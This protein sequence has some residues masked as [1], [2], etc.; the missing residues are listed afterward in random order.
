MNLFSFVDPVQRYVEAL[1]AG[2][3]PPRVRIRSAE[4]ADALKMAARLWGESNPA[5]SDPDPAFV[6]D[7]RYSMLQDNAPETAPATD[8]RGF[9][10]AGLSAT[11]CLAAGLLAGIG[12]ERFTS[13]SNLVAP[14]VVTQPR[15]RIRNRGRWFPIAR[16]SELGDNAVVRFSAGALE[17]NLVRR[18][19]E[20]FAI[21]AICSHLPCTLI[22]QQQEDNFL[23]PC[24]STPFSVYGKK[25]VERSYN[26]LTSIEVSVEEGVVRV[27]SV[28][29]PAGPPEGSAQF[30]D[31]S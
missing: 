27:W 5:A 25:L 31:Y 22:Y 6:A 26:D 12:L 19:G 10:A 30:T 3:R 4:D 13:A 28:D 2:K 24:H 29:P 8:R 18:D 20:V 21:S 14:P 15:L 7:L 1:L 17:G 9:I 23:C 11:A 16:L